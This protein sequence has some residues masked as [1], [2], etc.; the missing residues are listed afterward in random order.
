L[1]L[2][3]LALAIVNVLDWEEM[4]VDGY[5]YLRATFHPKYGNTVWVNVLRRNPFPLQFHKSQ[6]FHLEATRN[7]MKRAISGYE[8]SPARALAT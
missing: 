5:V 3:A 1:A 4:L 7:G 2:A 8:S 6:I